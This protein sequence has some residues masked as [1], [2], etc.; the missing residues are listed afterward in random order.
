MVI[1]YSNPVQLWQIHNNMIGVLNTEIKNLIR[2]LNTFYSVWWLYQRVAT[3]IFFVPL[4]CLF[5]TSTTVRSNFFFQNWWR[6][7]LSTVSPSNFIWIKL[8]KSILINW[9]NYYCYYFFF[10]DQLPKSKIHQYLR[11]SCT[12]KKK[13]NLSIPFCFLVPSFVISEVGVS[14]FQFLFHLPQCQ[15]RWPRL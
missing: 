15:G 6:V 8:Y 3:Q 9:G 2:K 13:K 5:M 12:K 11:H 4:C 14:S 1:T 10:F 7:M